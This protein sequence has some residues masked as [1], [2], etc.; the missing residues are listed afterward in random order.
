MAEVERLER[1][2][3]MLD[4]LEKEYYENC[5]GLG[6]DYN[7]RMQD[8]C[9]WICG[10]IER[11]ERK[12]NEVERLKKALEREEHPLVRQIIRDKIEELEKEREKNEV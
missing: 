5:D 2:R 12:I 11:L 10:E 1:L 7:E 3:K 4:Q 9:R 8:F 6:W